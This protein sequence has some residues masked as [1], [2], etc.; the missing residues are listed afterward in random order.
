MHSIPDSVKM[1][2]VNGRQIQSFNLYVRFRETS[3]AAAALVVLVGEAALCLYM[4]S[5]E[6]ARGQCQS[7]TLGLY[8]GVGV[9]RDSMG[10][11]IQN[12]DAEG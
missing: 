8:V 11:L 5:V 7:S 3:A 9:S 12:A 1:L 4:D 6:K 2:S 10:C